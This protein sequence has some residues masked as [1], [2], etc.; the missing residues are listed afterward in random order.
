M[1]YDGFT[2]E[3]VIPFIAPEGCLSVFDEFEFKPMTMMS[4]LQVRIRDNVMC[5][6][7]GEIFYILNQGRFIPRDEVEVC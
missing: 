7:D 2:L 3:E 6:E 1:I 5:T 4:V